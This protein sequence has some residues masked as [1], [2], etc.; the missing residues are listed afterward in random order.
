MENDKVDECAKGWDEKSSQE[1][2]QSQLPK[3]DKVNI[4][5]NCHFVTC[6]L[7]IS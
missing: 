2:H 1:L 3:K 7:K 5:Y 6:Q 4:D